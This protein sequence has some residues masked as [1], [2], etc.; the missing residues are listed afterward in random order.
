MI[1]ARD[2]WDIYADVPYMDDIIAHH[3]IRLSIFHK[4]YEKYSS[5]QGVI[6]HSRFIRFTKEY[7]LTPHAS[8]ASV[9]HVPPQHQPMLVAGDIDLIFKAA[10]KSDP[11]DHKAPFGT[12][13][14][15]FV[16]RSQTSAA[17]NMVFHQF[18]QAISM[19][20]R[21][22]YAGFVEERYGTVLEY[23]PIDQREP[24]AQDLMVDLIKGKVLGGMAH[25]N[26]VPFP[27]FF[28]ERTL[29]LLSTRSNMFGTLAECA[30]RL[31]QWFT[32]YADIRAP[33]TFDD[34][35][36]TY[37]SFKAL[38]RFA[39]DFGLVPFLS[40]E[41]QL[42]SLFEE[43]L[44]WKRGQG[45]RLLNLLPGELLRLAG[46]EVGDLST[47]PTMEHTKQPRTAAIG[48][49]SAVPPP[50]LKTLNIESHRGNIGPGVFGLLLVLVSVQGFP[51]HPEDARMDKLIDWMAQSAG[52]SEYQN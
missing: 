28:V 26:M 15:M 1:A 11:E 32:S 44:V 21:K 14:R 36:S 4:L 22:L 19:L 45:E 50:S 51:D 29:M 41:S 9:Q 35:V 10:I 8:G 42:F 17:S 49:P 5:D 7:L 40:R 2:Q 20:A 6:T 47:P 25:Q 33:D 27:M 38:L 30:P 48:F 31:V 37:M 52:G 43:L 39:H 13:P 18:I 12:G 3:H 34:D 23:L 24:A 16:R 46:A